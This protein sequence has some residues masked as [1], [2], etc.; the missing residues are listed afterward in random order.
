VTPLDA[1]RSRQPWLITPEALDH[2]AARASAFGDGPLFQNDPRTHPFLS[3]EDGV[4]IVSLH[5]PL[6]RR[7]GLIESAL[8]GAVDTEDAFDAIREAVNNEKVGAVLLDIDSPGGTV[9]GT[10]ELAE[11]VAD[12]SRE[13]P[14]YAFSA[15]L[16]CSASYWVASQADAVYASPSA[17]VGSIGVII[18][19]LD[20]AEAYRQAGLHM[21]VFASGRF[22]GLGTPGTSLTDDQRALLR[23]EV[24]E[25]FA[26]FRAAVLARGRK[27]PDDAMEGQTFSARQAQRHHLAGLAKNRDAV[28]ARLRRLHGSRVDTAARSMPSAPMNSI[29][30]Q[31]AEA[32]ARIETLETEAGERAG[33]LAR[34][35]AE[36]DEA[37]TALAAR[38]A[39]LAAAREE[40][41]AARADLTRQL[42]EERAAAVEQHAG[43]RT[44][45]EQLTQQVA[46]LTE[47]NAD[48][49]A[50]E[51]ELEKRAALRAAQIAAETGSTT[52]AHVTP[53][54][55][56]QPGGP[57]ESAADVWN[58]Q[59]RST[60]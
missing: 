16:M 9:N 48:L 53:A 33:E 17:R 19:F 30:D 20:S 24:E 46:G 57:P 22:K 13:K 41:Q 1:I 40:Q 36:R 54:G 26:D 38:E 2:F 18:P 51:Q 44:E 52:P 42:E 21:E 55:D 8:F 3:V 45:I 37:R 58:R 29:D 50:R 32:L 31:L 10:P 14:V 6:I 7:P 27:I 49:A 4:G 35:S 5:G 25:I 28:L 56:G 59:F 39:E 34:V 47:A 23:G 11:A 15:G 12:A 60:P 43:A